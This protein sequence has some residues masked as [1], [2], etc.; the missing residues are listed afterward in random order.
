MTR[1]RKVYLLYIKSKTLNSIKAVFL[2]DMLLGTGIYLA[3]KIITSSMLL[4]SL[5]SMVGSEGYKWRLRRQGSR[6]ISV[7]RSEWS[8]SF[9]K[10]ITR[11]TIAVQ[12]SSI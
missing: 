3:T 7:P 10:P 2:I 12:S 6:L 5:G 11:I 8:M 9:K 1:T 4:A